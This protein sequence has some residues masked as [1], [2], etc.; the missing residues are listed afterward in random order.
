MVMR[1]DTNLLA[2]A[3]TLGLGGLA[4]GAA[5]C[6]W[7]VFDEL[8]DET[9]VDRVTKPDATD[10]RQY[11]EVVLATPTRRPGTN[12]VVVGRAEASISQLRYDDDGT[13]Q[14]VASIDPTQPLSFD[15]FAENP[16]FAVDQDTDRNACAIVQGANTD[17]TRVAV[18]D[19]S[20]LSSTG[21]L[22]SIVLPQ[23][24]G[25]PA[26]ANLLAEGI[27]FA[28]LPSFPAGGNTQ[29]E[30]VLARGPTLLVLQDYDLTDS[31]VL[32]CVHDDEWSFEVAVGDVDGAHPGPELIVA[33]G[34]ERR[35]GPSRIQIIAPEQVSTP[36]TA[37]GGCNAL[38][39]IVSPEG[40][41]DLGSQL[42]VARFPDDVGSDDLDD[43]VYSAPSLNKVFVRFASGQ[44]VEINAGDQGSDFGDAVAVADLDGDGVPEV[45]VGAPKA[46]T[47]GVANG[48]AVYVFAFD[49]TASQRFRQVA[50]F[51]PAAPEAEER[52]G[53]SVT[54]AP[55]GAGDKHVLV[56]GAEGEVFTYFRTALYDDVRTGRGGL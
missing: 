38:A 44:T 33:T 17:P 36:Y 48:G 55:F 35:D 8:A 32:G 7:M 37:P 5:G 9:W 24:A 56:I 50:Q 53:K 20:A 3:A 23:A 51:G 31:P 25:T 21:P 27:A 45:I 40:P 18:Y 16:T 11:G 22:K 42:V 52:F 26:R 46:D 29:K 41:M 15:S 12:I 13:R 4:T 1:A 10:S 43:L 19:G 14:D 34:A 6:N 28:N 49:D 30:L 54:V 47:G 39:Q 2:I